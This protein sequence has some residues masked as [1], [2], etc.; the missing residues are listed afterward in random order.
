MP[1]DA[2]L[3]EG[4][5]V[6][7]SKLLHTSDWHLGR[8]LYQ[9]SREEDFDAVLAEIVAIA[10]ETVPDLI[11]HSGDLF[12]SS[13]PSSRDLIRAMRTLDQ[14]AAVAPTVVLA[15]NHDSPAYFEFLHYVSGPSRRRGLFF[16]DQLRPANDGGILTFPACGGE[17]RIRLAVMPFVHPNRFWRHSSA[18]GPAHADAAEGMRAVQAEL[19][20][21]LQEG[22]DPDRDVLVFAA[23]AFVAG[24]TLSHSERAVDVDEA[25]ATAPADLPQVSY[26]ALGHIHGPQTLNTNGRVIA[27]YSGSPLQ[28]DFGE[29]DDV[30]S[31]SII[32]ADP[33]RPAK[34]VPRPLTSGRRLHWFRGTLDEL[35]ARAAEYDGVFLRA[36]INGEEPDAQLTLKVAEIVPNAILCRALPAGHAAGDL[37]VDPGSAET[38]TLPEAFL[39]YLVEQGLTGDGVQST[40]AAFAQ[41]LGELDDETPPPS[42][43]ELLLRAALEDRWTQEV[44]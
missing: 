12:D 1:C 33:G 42:P 14:L 27:R 3:L 20:A 5:N 34:P 15:G 13:R 30:K 11:I 43:S 25:Y 44:S 16:V 9:H 10:Q 40:V 31:V 19:M 29:V 26:A 35:R 8:T 36:E 37:V 22:A 18:F 23:H 6:G 7:M 24:A 17:Q 41:L 38:P 21:G 39:A 32:Q 2:S 4:R 28:L